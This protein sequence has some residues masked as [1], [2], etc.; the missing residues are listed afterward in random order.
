MAGMRVAYIH[1]HITSVQ[2]TSTRTGVR[3]AA[4]VGTGG[5]QCLFGW[6]QD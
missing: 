1:I 2:A 6:A 5:L 3:K 4:V